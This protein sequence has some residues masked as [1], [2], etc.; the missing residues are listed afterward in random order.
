MVEYFLMGIRSFRTLKGMGWIG[1]GF[2]QK[3]VLL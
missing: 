3:E 2:F 1:W